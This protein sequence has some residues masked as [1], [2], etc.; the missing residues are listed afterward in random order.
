MVGDSSFDMG[1]ARAAGVLPI[2]VSWGFQP[3]SALTEA[4]AGP[5]VHSYAELETTLQEFVG[6]PSKISA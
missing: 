2:G 4:G 3:V 5:I 1:M 6:S